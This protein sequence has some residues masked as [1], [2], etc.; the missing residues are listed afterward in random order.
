MLLRPVDPDT[1][2]GVALT[3]ASP[4]KKATASVGVSKGD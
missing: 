1:A 3:C 2:Q 4:H